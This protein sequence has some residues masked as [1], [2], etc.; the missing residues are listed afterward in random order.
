MDVNEHINKINQ[1]AL[2]IFHHLHRFPELSEE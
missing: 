2:E 1:N